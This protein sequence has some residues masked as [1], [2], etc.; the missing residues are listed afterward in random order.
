VEKKE[1]RRVTMTKRLLKDALTEILRE[2]NIYHISIRELCLRADVNRTTFYK[3]YGSQFDLLGDMEGDFLDFL[4]AAIKKH[5]DDPVM[6]IKTACEYLEDHL[7]FA[8]LIINNNV[9]PLF[10]RKL[11][12]LAAVREAA[13]SSHTKRKDEVD[14]EYFFNY[15]AYGA[16]RVIC[17]WLN[18]DERESPQQISGQLI[19]MLLMSQAGGREAL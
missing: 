11:F 10:P 14:P 2:R 4:S 1:D 6:I 16:Y 8:R 15:I 13:L 18:K 17:V 9:D 5:T 7:D 12:S 3:Y 19:R